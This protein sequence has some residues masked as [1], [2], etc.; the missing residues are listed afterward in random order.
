VEA[1]RE[2]RLL[3]PPPPMPLAQAVEQVAEGPDA[4]ELEV[5]TAWGA[6]VE[7]DA[8]F[9]LV[10]P[11]GRREEAKLSAGRFRKEQAGARNVRV[12]F[13]FISECRWS[14]PSAKE[15]EDV[16]L[17][18]FTSGLGNGTPVT[19]RV[20]DAWRTADQGTLHEQTVQVQDN[21]AVGR[22]RFAPGPGAAARGDFVFEA[23]SGS[24]W[25]TSGVLRV[26]PFPVDDVRGVKQRLRQLGYDPGPVDAALNAA[27]RDA[28]KQFQADVGLVQPE[29]ELTPLTREALESLAPV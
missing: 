15:G 24:N 5:R 9:E 29:G 16:D 8:G 27:V 28:L 12:R 18:V 1:P 7:D 2:A 4:L 23:E 17:R 3:A 11:D 14:L 19:L 26:E 10:F 20:Y 22:W 6:P 21:L 25:A 13:R